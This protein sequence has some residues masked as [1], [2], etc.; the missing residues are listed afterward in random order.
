MASKWLYA[1]LGLVA[2][3][4]MAPAQSPPLSPPAD[5]AQPPALAENAEECPTCAD[6]FAPPCRAWLSAEYLLWK[7]PKENVPVLVGT[8]PAA[9]AELS[10][11]LPAGII[12]PLF[13]GPGSPVDFGWQSGWRVSGGYWFDPDGGFGLD[14]GFFQLPSAGPRAAFHSGGNP[15][16]GPVF[17]D[18]TVN[19]AVLIMSSVPGL[20]TGSVDVAL[21]QGLWGAEINARRRLGGGLLPIPLDLLA[22][23]RFIEVDNG[24]DVN[25]DDAAIPNGRAP[26]G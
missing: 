8:V 19:Q 10:R 25:G 16:V 18:S 3:V 26:C 9:Q 14:G 15:V 21:D 23:F 17:Q 20:R 5:D 12:R 7:L 1:V 24:I 6:A 2:A 11:S 22:G 13:G 4:R